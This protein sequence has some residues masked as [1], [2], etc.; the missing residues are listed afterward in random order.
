MEHSV[1]IIS[2]VVLERPASA[3]AGVKKFLNETLE[4]LLPEGT[5]GGVLVSE[6][7]ELV[8]KKFPKIKDKNQCYT[9]VNNF[10]QS[11]RIYDKGYQPGTRRVVAARIDALAA[12]GKAIEDLENED[13]VNNDG[14]TGNEE[15]RAQ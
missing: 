2:D 1:K 6:L 4:E 13:E 12:A 7:A 8:H 14:G 10:L 9:R 3:A 11:S 15:S 5:Q